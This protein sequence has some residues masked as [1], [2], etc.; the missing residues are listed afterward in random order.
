M[1]C[2][3]TVARD[4][5]PK[6]TLGPNPL[7]VIKGRPRTG[8]DDAWLQSARTEAQECLSDK[9]SIRDRT[10]LDVWERVSW[11]ASCNDDRSFFGSVAR[12]AKHLRMGRSTVQRSMSR[13]EAR[14]VFVFAH[15]TGGHAS[16]SSRG[17]FNLLVVVLKTDRPKVVTVTDG[18]KS[19]EN[20]DLPEPVVAVRKPLE[21][22]FEGGEQ[23]L[24]QQDPSER[25]HLRHKVRPPDNGK[26]VRFWYGLQR[27]LGGWGE[28]Y[29][30]Q[31]AQIFARLTHREQV[32]VINRLLSEEQQA[33]SSGSLEA[34]GGQQ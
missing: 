18:S 19:T 27:R 9:P 29:L 30:Q 7:H 4:A 25:Q 21:P 24:G 23:P 3:H 10:D 2:L 17:R 6:T 20:L 12:L 14:G 33:V 5:P 22:N 34:F 11:L 26:R 28:Q 15:R 13:W 1:N 16:Q 31:Q 8:P 32:Q